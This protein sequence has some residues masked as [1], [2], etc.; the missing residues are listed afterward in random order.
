MSEDHDCVHEADIGK[1]K[2]ELTN[3]ERWQTAQNGTLARIED[4]V[5]Y[6]LTDIKKEFIASLDSTHREFIASMGSSHKEFAESLINV[7]KRFKENWDNLNRKFDRINAWMYGL[8]G[9]LI[10]ALILL[11][12]NLVLGAKK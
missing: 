12:L 5:E 4:K 10:L 11:A 1:M 7:N 8:M 6:S 9:S 2:A 3:L